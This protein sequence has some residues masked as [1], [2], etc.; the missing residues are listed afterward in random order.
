MPMQAVQLD[1]CF[2]GS[3]TNARIEDLRTAA[4][5]LRE[6]AV[7][8]SITL[9]IVPGS[10]AVLAQARAEGLDKIFAAAGA[11]FRLPGCSLCIGMNDD[12]V[13][14]GKRCLSTSN[15]NFIGR[16]GPGSITHLASPA[17]VAASAI[18]GK[19]TSPAAYF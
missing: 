12:K 16:Q 4:A 18:E 11:Q 8:P 1:W 7:H 15:R 2:I 3:C 14:A 5:I 9:Y 6:R 13:P 10:E 17:T 19:I